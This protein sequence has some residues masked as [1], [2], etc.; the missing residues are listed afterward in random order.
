MKF[1]CQHLPVLQKAQMIF[2]VLLQAKDALSHP[3]FDDLE[4]AEV[5]ALE[6][7]VVRARTG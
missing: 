7:E 6:S 3:Y 1:W 2:Q 5:D 4:K